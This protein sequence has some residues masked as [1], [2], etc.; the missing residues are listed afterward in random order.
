MSPY[1]VGSFISWLDQLEI[2]F[3]KEAM[4]DLMME[5]WGG[6]LWGEDIPLSG[7]M[8]PGE[9]SHLLRSADVFAFEE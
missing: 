4:S 6:V 2:T 7:R 3:E 9:L 8:E 1:R 5:S